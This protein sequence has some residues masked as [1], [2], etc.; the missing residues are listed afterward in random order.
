MINVAKLLVSTKRIQAL[1]PKT[2]QLAITGSMPTRLEV[3]WFH[4]Q[5]VFE[6]LTCLSFSLIVL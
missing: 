3:P 1:V 2:K 6:V 5:V 4:K